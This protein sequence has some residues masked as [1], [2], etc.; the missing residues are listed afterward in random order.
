VHKSYSVRLVARLEGIE[1]IDEYDI[2]RFGV[3]LIN[4]VWR[5]YLPGSKGRYYEVHYLDE[6]E[7]NRILP[8]IKAYLEAKK[9]YGI[10]GKR[11]PVEIVRQGDVGA[12]KNANVD[13]TKT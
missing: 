1:Y 2:Y 8:R 6:E 13:G 9:Y 5:L 10:F 3:A 12:L 11:F 7:E 4:G